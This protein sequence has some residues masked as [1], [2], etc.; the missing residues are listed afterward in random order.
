[1]IFMFIFV[2][3][4]QESFREEMVKIP[5]EAQFLHYR[6]FSFVISSLYLQ[7]IPCCSI[8]L[9][10]HSPYPDVYTGVLPFQ[11]L[12]FLCPAFF[13]HFPFFIPCL[14]FSKNQWISSHPVLFIEISKNIIYCLENANKPRL[15]KT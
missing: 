6:L 4:I 11:G 2:F 7:A 1:M 15:S 12:S 3:I 8:F 13:L 14:S 10:I 5:R 9:H